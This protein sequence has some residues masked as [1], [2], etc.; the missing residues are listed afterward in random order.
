MYL[1]KEVEIKEQESHFKA[2]ING[3]CEKAIEIHEL[4]IQVK[5]MQETIEMEREDHDGNVDDFNAAFEAIKEENLRLNNI[6]KTYKD[7]AAQK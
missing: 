2:I 3:L 5:D 4:R 7:E 1:G 6:L